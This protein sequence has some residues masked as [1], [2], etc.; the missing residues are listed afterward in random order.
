MGRNKT[1]FT[2]LNNAVF[3]PMPSARAAIAVIVITGLLRRVRAAYFKSEK[4]IASE[5]LSVFVTVRSHG[6][7]LCRARVT[8]SSQIRPNSAHGWSYRQFLLQGCIL[9]RKNPPPTSR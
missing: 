3:A 4:D 6:R 2:T 5:L 7:T 8:P 9:R 1:A